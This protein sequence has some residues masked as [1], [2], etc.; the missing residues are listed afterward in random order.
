MSKIAIDL[1][2]GDIKKEERIIVGIDLGTTNSLIA[3]I[4]D[5]QPTVMPDHD[6]KSVLVPSVIYFDEN[7]LAS[8]GEIA[9]DKLI[10]DPSRTI[11]SVKRLMGR[12]FND[13]ENSKEFFSYEILAERR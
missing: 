8:I 1:K 6:G 5:G 10:S 13:V 4:N 3:Y 7:D 2:S 9:K 12:S 11:F